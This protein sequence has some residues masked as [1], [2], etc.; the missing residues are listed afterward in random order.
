MLVMD[1]KYRSK[2]NMHTST[3][4]LKIRWKIEMTRKPDGHFKVEQEDKSLPQDLRFLGALKLLE[5]IADGRGSLDSFVTVASSIGHALEDW[6]E[7]G[8]QLR[9]KA[10]I[11]QEKSSLTVGIE[12]YGEW[13]SAH[14]N[15]NYEQ[16]LM[17]KNGTS[18]RLLK[19]QNVLED[20]K[21]LENAPNLVLK[22]FSSLHKL[23]KISNDLKRLVRKTISAFFPNRTSCWGF[24]EF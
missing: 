11:E 22:R 14:D 15:A 21:R 4:L 8:L 5:Q 19:L 6:S 1:S 9:I 12:H 17:A 2:T 10:L 7:G 24:H 13:R 3:I 20:S 23:I 18:P 16:Y